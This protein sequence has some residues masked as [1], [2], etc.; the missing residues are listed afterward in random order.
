MRDYPKAIKRQI[1]ELSF[2][3][4]DEELRRALLPLA[5]AFDEWNQGRRP[6]GEMIQMIHKFDHGPQRQIYNRYSGGM[7]DLMVASA[8]VSGILDRSKVTPEVLA[9]LADV[10]T[11]IEQHTRPD[12][13]TDEAEPSIR[14][15]T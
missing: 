14:P 11:M 6:N 12:E 9:A 7:Q 15:V 8:I 5:K 4:Q 10:M 13:G 2:Q 3:A 1:N